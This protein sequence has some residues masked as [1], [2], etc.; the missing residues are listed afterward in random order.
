MRTP[1]WDLI[2]W[3]ELSPHRLGAYYGGSRFHPDE[4]WFS[5]NLQMFAEGPGRLYIFIPMK[6][7]FH[8]SSLSSE[9]GKLF[10]SESLFFIEM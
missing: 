6:Y 10:N 3:A 9:S 2:G 8:G 5:G 4:V 1:L 7:F